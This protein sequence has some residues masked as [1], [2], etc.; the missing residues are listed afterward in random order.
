LLKKNLID[1]KDINYLNNDLGINNMLNKNNMIGDWNNIIIHIEKFQEELFNNRRKLYYIFFNSWIND[2]DK[3]YDYKPYKPYIIRKYWDMAKIYKKMVY[4][5]IKNNIV[6]DSAIIYLVYKIINRAECENY[7]SIN[8]KNCEY[9]IKIIY[10]HAIHNSNNNTTLC[11]NIYKTII[12]SQAIITIETKIFIF[13]Y[14][15]SYSLTPKL[16]HNNISL[17]IIFS[18]ATTY[19]N[20]N[21][22]YYS[23]IDKK[24]YTRL[25]HVEEKKYGEYLNSWVVHN[26]LNS[27]K[28]D[29]FRTL[30]KISITPISYLKEWQNQ[31]LIKDNI[32]KNIDEELPIIFKYYINTSTDNNELLE[33]KLFNMRYIPSVSKY[34]SSYKIFKSM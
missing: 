31:G 5:G 11:S 27:T 2:I 33:H 17:K 29:V 8:H 16:W 24:D 23:I 7:A 18:D 15:D 34:M 1:Y 14:T 20:I 32:L 6:F 4:D 30:I 19:T 26:I 28:N 21:T 25:W 12:N 13:H 10:Q 22:D 3:N 9:L